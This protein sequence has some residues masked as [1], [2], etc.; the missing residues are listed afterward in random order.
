MK[1]KLADKLKREFKRISNRLFG[2]NY[3]LNSSNQF[4]EDV[5]IDRSV[6]L[7]SDIKIGRGT[8]LRK[9]IFVD[10]GVEIGRYCSIANDVVIGP[11]NHPI[12]N[13]STHPISYD[14]DNFPDKNVKTIIGN[15][16]WIG[17]RAIIKRGIKIG[18]GAVIASGAIVTKDV[19][20][21]A[22]VAGV[23]AKII[24]YRFDSETIQELQALEW[25][26]LPKEKL[27]YGLKNLDIKEA[28]RELKKRKEE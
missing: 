20:P 24:K 10:D 17:T 15:D 8:Y 26:N 21:Y 13:F 18:N 16:V 25:W 22:V 4:E 27:I 6:V 7:M 3:P 14:I 5:I 2:T 9:D 19:E 28:I 1:L 12:T 23:P 11:S